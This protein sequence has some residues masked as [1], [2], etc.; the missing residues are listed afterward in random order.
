[1]RHAWGW[2]TADDRSV[3][4][5]RLTVALGVTERD[6]TL[7]FDA[8]GEDLD[9]VMEQIASKVTMTAVDARAGELLMLHANGLAD[10]HSG[11]AV[12][13]VG[14]SQ[15]GKTTAAMTLTPG[16][17]Y[18]TDEALAVDADGHVVA[19]P[20]PLS[21]RRD[22]RRE[23]VFP[24]SIG[25]LPPPEQPCRIAH[26]LLMNRNQAH[27]GGPLVELVPVVHALAEVA[28]ETSHLADLE[29]GLHRLAQLFDQDRGALRVTYRDAADLANLI[30]TLLHP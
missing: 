30:G 20:K 17:C 21:V 10:Q 18:L 14:P 5:H 9:G 13:M 28:S 29:R 12:M 4:E 15:A 24:A 2:C 6:A 19:Y 22:G 8:S 3:P 25:A 27:E 23:Q 26:V 11:R 16:R 7:S 1:M